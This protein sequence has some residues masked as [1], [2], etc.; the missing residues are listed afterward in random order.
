[1]A[2]D[3][4]MMMMIM[5]IGF[6]AVKAKGMCECG[7]HFEFATSIPVNLNIYGHEVML[8]CGWDMR[9]KMNKTIMRIKK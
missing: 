5:M 7:T 8:G 1:M 6:G 3:H 2:I 9:D 4:M